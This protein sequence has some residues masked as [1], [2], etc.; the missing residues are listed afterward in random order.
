MTV[1][2]CIFPITNFPSFSPAMPPAHLDSRCVLSPS[3]SLSFSPLSILFQIFMWKRKKVWIP[4]SPIS[5]SLSNID[6]SFMG[7]LTQRIIEN[8]KMTYTLLLKTFHVVHNLI[9]VLS[10]GSFQISW[11]WCLMYANSVENTCIH[12]PP[13]RIGIRK[14]RV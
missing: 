10:F 14:W 5:V 6:F 11:K 9:S 12:H 3:P 13:I 4:F 7:L 8:M 1:H 2:Q